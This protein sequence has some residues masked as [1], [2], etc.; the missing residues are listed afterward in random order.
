[1]AVEVVRPLVV[2]A[3][4]AAGGD[5][6]CHC[7]AGCILRTAESR[8]AVAADVVERPELILTVAHEDDA[9]AEDI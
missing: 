2:G 1:M 8:A 7:R 6:A 3:D 9:F 4:D 5:A